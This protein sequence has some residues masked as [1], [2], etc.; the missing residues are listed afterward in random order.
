[1]DALDDGSLAT[2]EPDDPQAIEVL[3]RWDELTPTGLERLGRQ[4]VLARRLAR[5]RSAE[6]WL[7]ELA[8]I[9]DAGCPAPDELYDFGR[10]PGYRPLT[11]ERRHAIEIHLERCASCET[12]VETLELSPPLPLELEDATPGVA[13][14]LAAPVRPRRGARIRRLLPLAAAA[15]LLV[16]AA[17]ARF[18]GAPEPG[19]FEPPLLR[20]ES[21]DALL[22]PRGPVLAPGPDAAWPLFAAAPLFEVVPVEG[23]TR[24][25]VVLQRHGGGAFDEGRPVARLEGPAAQLAGEGPLAAGFYTWEAWAEVDGLD[26]RLGAHDFH[27]VERPDLRA[28]LADLPPRRAVERLQRARFWSDARALARRLP[29]SA[30]R[31]AVLRWLPPR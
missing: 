4:P 18:G 2:L 20:G 23:A 19:A 26:R 13:P 31:D 24:Y 17:L 9:E 8:G 15:G 28:E 22:F 5:L 14:P 7:A 21:A 25:W 30:E 6:R 1:M 12:S 29:N 27:V 10:G 11:A 16:W 3:A